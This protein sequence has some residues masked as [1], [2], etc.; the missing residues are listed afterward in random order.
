MKAQVFASCSLLIAASASAQFFNAPALAL[1]VLVGQKGSCAKSFPELAEPLQ[2]AYR[3]FARLNSAVLPAEAF[4]E[5]DS[6]ND[7]AD[8]SVF[9]KADRTE[10]DNLIRRMPKISL[11]ALMDEQLKLNEQRRKE[12]QQ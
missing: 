9:A 7:L 4:T 3:E 8:S 12:E 10:C 2:S 1:V 11:Q 6:K 5:L